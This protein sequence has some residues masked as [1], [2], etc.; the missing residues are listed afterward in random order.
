[1]PYNSLRGNPYF[2][3]DARLAKNIKLGE[4]KNL[5]LVFQA[6]NVFNHANYGNSF[7]NVA[8]TLDPK[9]KSFATPN[10]GFADPNNF[11][12]PTSSTLPRAFT[13]EFGARFT[14]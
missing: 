1:M 3:V 2:D 12:N 5:Q 14:F 11:I 4:H 7:D 9:T 10:T 13:G 8:A 6:F